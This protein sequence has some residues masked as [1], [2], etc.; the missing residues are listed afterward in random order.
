[1]TNGLLE[2]ALSYAKRGWRVFPC[3]PKGKEPLTPSGFKNATTEE[4]QIRVWWQTWPDAN[5]AIATGNGLY[6]LDLDGPDGEVSVQGREIPD[7]PQVTTGK[8]RHCYFKTEEPLR[9]FTGKL[10]HVDGRG[11]GGYVIAPPS[12]HP[13][14]AVYRWTE[15]NKDIPLPVCPEWLAELARPKAVLTPSP[16]TDGEE[17]AILAGQRNAS[18]TSLA[19]TMRKRGMSPAA[20]EAALLEE[21]RDKCTPPLSEDEVRRIAASVAKYPAGAEDDAEL[22]ARA[23][24]A[25]VTLEQ[26]RRLLQGSDE[27][28]PLERLSAVFRVPVSEVLLEKSGRDKC[29]KLILEDGRTVPFG[30]GEALYSFRKVRAR[31]AENERLVLDCKPKEWPSVVEIILSQAREVVQLGS[32]EAMI[33][34]L[35]NEMLCVA[36][37]VEKVNGETLLS[38]LH[39]GVCGDD[40]QPVVLDAEGRLWTTQM[41]IAD[42]LERVK[43]RISGGRAITEVLRGFG[44]EN[45]IILKTVWK[46]KKR[47]WEDGPEDIEGVIPQFRAW[48]G[49]V[50]S[51]LAF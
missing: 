41:Y 23:A 22:R 47:S 6:V 25:G 9:L 30:D 10:P 24:K 18:L 16:R 39:S 3:R 51:D 19:G 27:M 12:V 26:A 36:E 11:E 7:G 13:S 20:I 1:M 33:L 5:V 48:C 38:G 49:F 28:N 21:N 45:R 44:F 15:G 4:A 29:F 42:R 35:L 50:P 14:G 37:R 34:D 31:L 17:Q 40:A 46:R 43:Y 32:D 2:A 8:G